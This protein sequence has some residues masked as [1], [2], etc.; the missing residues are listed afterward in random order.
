MCAANTPSSFS[1]RVRLPD[2]P[3][4]PGS[5][6]TLFCLESLVHGAPDCNEPGVFV[7]FEENSQRTVANAEGFGWKLAQLRRKKLCF[8]DT[9]PQPDLVS[10]GDFDRSGLLAARASEIAAMQAKRIVFDVLDVV[11]AL[12]S[13][14]SAQRR[15]IF[16]VCL[17]RLKKWVR[18]HRARCLVID[19]VSEWSGAG[20]DLTVR[21]VAECLIDWIK[22]G[23]ALPDD[24]AIPS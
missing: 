14:A 7:A 3:A 1:M 6:K 24:E 20:T 19:P 15:E 4:R 17:R 11:L 10:A 13:D 23:T 22:A 8:I 9:Q 5:G 18:A 12:L 2:W 16:R 21:G